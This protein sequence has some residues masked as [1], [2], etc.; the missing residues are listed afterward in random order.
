M[1]IIKMHYL[2]YKQGNKENYMQKNIDKN[3]DTLYQERLERSKLIL[4]LQRNGIWDQI[5]GTVPPEGENYQP[6][7][8]DWDKIREEIRNF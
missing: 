5:H 2:K 3:Q 1:K 4:E 6:T 8:E 7:K